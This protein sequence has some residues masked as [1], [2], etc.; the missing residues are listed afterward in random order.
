MYS[1]GIASLLLLLTQVRI[2]SQRL[3]FEMPVKYSRHIL[4]IAMQN[5]PR[6]SHQNMPLYTWGGPTT[7]QVAWPASGGPTTR[8]VAWPT[9]L[10]LYLSA[11]PLKLNCLSVLLDT[12]KLLKYALCRDLWD[13]ILQGAVL[14]LE[15][16]DALLRGLLFKSFG[17]PLL[18]KS[19]GRRVF[20]MSNG[21][22]LWIAASFSP[23]CT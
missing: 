11:A 21:G 23:C 14:R 15:R 10:T 13:M 4:L 17:R 1:L 8:Q 19:F 5:V 2:L 3:R 18:F 6:V 9:S 16:V 20:I 7:R 22:F 12:D